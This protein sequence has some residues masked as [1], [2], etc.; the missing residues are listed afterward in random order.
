MLITAPPAPFLAPQHCI[1]YHLR[2]H[3]Q[4]WVI[5]YFIVNNVPLKC[6]LIYLSDAYSILTFQAYLVG[7]PVL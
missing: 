2:I 7:L 3:S 6:L 4:R 1:S 5:Q